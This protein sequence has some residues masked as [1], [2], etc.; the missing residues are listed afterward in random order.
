MAAIIVRIMAVLSR[1]LSIKQ[2]VH[3]HRFQLHQEFITPRLRCLACRW[4]RVLLFLLFL[5]LDLPQDLRNQDVMPLDLPKLSIVQLIT[6]AQFSFNQLLKLD[7]NPLDKLF[8][9]ESETYAI[10]HSLLLLHLIN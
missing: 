7:F 1:L 10:L 3:P 8:F 2:K 4:S 5:W 9:Q 6:L